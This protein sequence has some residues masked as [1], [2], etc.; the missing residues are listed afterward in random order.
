MNQELKELS[1]QVKKNIENGDYETAYRT[2]TDAM[3]NYPDSGIPHNL[4][5]IL[6]EYRRNHVG[7]MKHLRAAWAL[8]PTLLCA[9]WNLEF[10]GEQRRTGRCAYVDE[11]VPKNEKKPRYK[12]VYDERGIGHMVRREEE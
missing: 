1:L 8:E 3:K 6:E 5:G 9:R 12:C 7:A 11:D 4:L 10:Y 2:I